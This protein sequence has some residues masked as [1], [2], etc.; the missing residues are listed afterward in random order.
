MF[1][2][3]N[4]YTTPAQRK[5]KTN[6]QINTSGAPIFQ[7]GEGQGPNQLELGKRKQPSNWFR[8][9]VIILQSLTSAVY[10]HTHTFP[11]GWW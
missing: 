7:A 4:G 3:T 5:V 9:T 10:T 2:I 11:A 8:V 1:N 6:W